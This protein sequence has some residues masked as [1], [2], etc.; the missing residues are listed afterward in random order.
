MCKIVYK[1]LM[2][3]LHIS[4]T[5]ETEAER[6]EGEGEIRRVGGREE[7]SEKRRERRRAKGKEGGR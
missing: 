2:L 3:F 4:H 7:R 1:F 6:K 5:G